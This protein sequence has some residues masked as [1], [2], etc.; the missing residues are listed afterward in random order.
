MRHAPAIIG[1]AIM[2]TRNTNR[3]SGLLWD[4]YEYT[5]LSALWA[6]YDVATIARAIDRSPASV[7]IMATKVGL[8]R[9]SRHQ[10]TKEEWR[11]VV[12][13]EAYLAGVR[14]GV[15]LADIRNHAACV[16]RWRAWN[17]LKC[18]STN[19][20]LAG[21]GRCVGRD[22]TSIRSGLIRLQKLQSTQ[23]REKRIRYEG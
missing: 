8:S 23:P 11:T 21:V 9:T 4:S 5:A 12:S 19:Y 17:R 10:P 2:A 6:K 14:V 16:A 1:I 7:G 20:S 15:I 13:Q 22:H 18:L 3:R